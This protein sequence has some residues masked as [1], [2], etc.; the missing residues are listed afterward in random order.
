MLKHRRSL[1]LNPNAMDVPM[2]GGQDSGVDPRVLQPGSNAVVENGRLTV[3]GQVRK[4][5]G[6]TEA[7]SPLIS[8]GVQ[9]FSGGSVLFEHD[10]DS[11]WTYNDQLQSWTNIGRMSGGQIR[12][13]G[14]V[15]SPLTVQQV[16]SA[17]VGD[18]MLIA[19]TEQTPGPIL[20][21]IVDLT[22]G[23]QLT[24]RTALG[25]GQNPQ[26]LSIDSNFYVFFGDLST[27]SPFI[28]KVVFPAAT[29]PIVP[30]PSVKVGN[31][32]SAATK[33]DVI[34]NNFGNAFLMLAED[35]TSFFPATDATLY[36]V[37]TTSFVSVL[38]VNINLGANQPSVFNTIQNADGDV[39]GGYNAGTAIVVRSAGAGDIFPNGGPLN[40]EPRRVTGA[41]GR[42]FIET[43][44]TS[45]IIPYSL[46]LNA[47]NPLQYDLTRDGETVTNQVGVHLTGRAFVHGTNVYA[48]VNVDDALQSIDMIIDSRGAVIAVAGANGG[49]AS[50]TDGFPSLAYYKDNGNGDFDA[51][52]RY[53]T[54]VQ[55]SDTGQIQTTVGITM[56]RFSLGNQQIYP[57]QIDNVTYMGCSAPQ[58]YDGAQLTEWGF[59]FYPQISAATA[60]ATSSG[61]LNGGLYDVSACY[62]WYD[63]TGKVWRS[64]TSFFETVTVPSTGSIT[65]TVPYLWQTTK[66]NVW[67]EIYCTANVGGQTGS[68]LYQAASF[69]NLPVILDPVTFQPTT[70]S[71]ATVTISRADLDLADELQL[72]TNGGAP[73]HITPPSLVHMSTSGLR[74]YG[75][76]N[77]DNQVY[78]TS[79]AIPG[80]PLDFLFSQSVAVESRRGGLVASQPQDGNLW[81]FTLRALFLTNADINS[82]GVTNAGNVVLFSPPARAAFGD[83]CV[84]AASVFASTDGIYY[85]SSRGIEIVTRNQQAVFVGEPVKNITGTIIDTYSV[86]SQQQ[87]RF[88]FTDKLVC[89]DYERR[90]WVQYAFASMPEM[91]SGCSWNGLGVALTSNGVTRLEDTS[92]FFDDGEMPIVMRLQTPWLRLGGLAGWGKAWEFVVLGEQITAC[93]MQVQIA[94]NDDP[95]WIDTLTIP[96]ALIGT[97]F[98][99]GQTGA[100]GQTLNVSQPSMFG[101]NPAGNAYKWLGIIPR[102]DGN[103]FKFEFQTLNS[104]GED[105]RL[106]YMTLIYGLQPG[107]LAQFPTAR[108]FG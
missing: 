108:K 90:N 21:C 83:G 18:L 57:E 49:A 92:T 98:G 7:F 97:P 44:P 53:L 25:Y 4:R 10:G 70:P 96:S 85:Q 106:N 47:T 93:D 74:H 1:A 43:K 2:F 5:Y 37:A 100:F 50:G 36:S 8:T 101:N 34:V 46:V 80:Q 88:V 23:A 94:Y 33:F 64:A 22:T 56:R 84:S 87:I 67:V 60:G 75:C 48:A 105:I 55:I 86:P 81:I 72:Y 39:L 78:V 73:D 71:T 107:G 62:S 31:N 99:G 68:I 24:T 51:A 32:T 14:A 29:Y 79:P 61:L 102:A 52:T 40:Y 45:S 77:E 103:S 66:D 11:V 95:T 15:Q 89:Y 19:W 63:A 20:Y 16:S 3:R 17:I 104:G 59:Y 12:T 28:A 13:L 41:N 26:V 91:I 82:L 30:Y 38:S 76:C 6:F 58:I 65:V 69:A 42:L 35:V 27:P 9:V 54:T